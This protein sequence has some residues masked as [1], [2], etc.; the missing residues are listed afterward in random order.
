M[1]AT[2]L[3]IQ[4]NKSML[5]ST[6][7]RLP[8]LLRYSFLPIAD[9]AYSR[10][11]LQRTAVMLLFWPVFLLYLIVTG[12]CLALDHLLFPRFKQIAIQQPLFVIGI[13]RS[14]T[15]F[16]HRLLAADQERFTT[17]T[18]QE[19]IFAPSISQRL[20]WRALAQLDHRLGSPATK[21]IQWL[22][23]RVFSPLDGVHS[24][25]LDDPEE[26]YLALAPLLNCFLLILPFGDPRFM[27]LSTFDRD[28]SPQQKQDLARFYRGLIQRHL[29]VHGT[30]NTYLSKNP[31]FTPMLQTLAEAFP[32]ARF[33]ACL[34]NPNQAVPSQVSS[35]L[36][37]AR[38]FSG[39]LDT[40]WWRANLM[41]MLQFYYQHLMQNLPALGAHRHAFVRMEQLAEAPQATVSELYQSFELPL[42]T[43]YQNQLQ[44]EEASARR[45]QSGH[46]YQGD[47]LG[48]TTQDLQQQF[49]FVYDQ[50]G[51]GLPE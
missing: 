14:G 40:H 19:L 43:R 1:L 6:L 30:D 13:P 15:T 3:S 47:T 33:V 41:R 27:T 29:F 23:K 4:V 34:R 44:Q 32:D 28:A 48:I 8:R 9:G 37:G 12:L 21:T 45:Y 46:R 24:T 18:L 38:L 2:K 50:L 11:S 49:G 35:I 51:Y 17:M 26:D 42:S 16:L 31:S 25:R 20:C 5:G 22:E 10:F 36:M 39:Q 7:M